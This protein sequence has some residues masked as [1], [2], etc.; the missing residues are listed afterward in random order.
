MMVP[1]TCEQCGASFPKLSQ[2]LQ[3]RRAM[4]HWQKY[5]C[6]SCK[7]VFSRKDNLER[8]MKKHNSDNSH[9]CPDC[10]KV[11]ISEKAL[12]RHIQQNHKQFGGAAKRTLREQD[13]DHENKRQKLET[14]D[15]VHFVMNK[16]SERKLEKFRTT[17][18]YYKIYV[19]DVEER[20]LPN[21]LKYLKT[22]FQETLNRMA[23]DIPSTDLV[24]LSMD[25]PELDYPIVLPFMRRSD[26]T[27]ERVL[28]EIERVLQSY[29]QFVIDETFGMELVHVQAVSGSGYKMKPVV[30]LTK[31][32]NMKKSIIQIKNKDDMCCARAIVTAIA[33]H[34]KHPQW[35]NIRLGRYIQGKL[36]EELHEKVSVPKQTC[37][38]DDVKTFQS[39]LTD[40]QIHVLSKEYFNAII[41]S[42]PDGGVPIYLYH[43][44]RHFDV[45]TTMTGFLKRSYYCIECKKGYDHKERHSCNNPCRYCRHLHTDKEE[46]WKHCDLCNCRFINMEC[47]S[48]HLKKSKKGKS[49]CESYYKCQDCGQLINRSKHKHAHVCGETY[50]NTCK[51]YVSED[52]QCFMQSIDD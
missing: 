39:V 26:L 49:T 23:S 36:A 17:A 46:Q 37:T 1:Y 11:F 16:V 5:Q 48:L 24:R 43:H 12:T 9:H 6:Q 30:D 51:D 32:L 35:N 13:D 21:I 10:L 19:D 7:K 18:S 15:G 22:L 42:G 28:A 33:R 45:I 38:I 27:V 2:L 50:C 44:D 29:E 25:N 34:E 14:E 52:H 4:N 40:Y 47:Y 20:D 41:Y 31:M 8:H 3:H